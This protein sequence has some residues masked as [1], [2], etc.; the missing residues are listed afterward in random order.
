MTG[1]HPFEVAA[2]VQVDGHDAPALVPD[3]LRPGLERDAR[4]ELLVHA[5]ADLAVAEPRVVEALDHRL[6]RSSA[7][8]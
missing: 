4:S 7:S 2:A 6:H 1:A 5:G 3:A 8:G